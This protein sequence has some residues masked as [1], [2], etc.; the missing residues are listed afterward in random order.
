M[1]LALAL[2]PS[3]TKLSMVTYLRSQRQ[4]QAELRPEPKCSDSQSI[5]LPGITQ[6]YTHKGV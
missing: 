6:V 1:P 5:E 2:A 3:L 4:L